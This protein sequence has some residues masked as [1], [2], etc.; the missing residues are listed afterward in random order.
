MLAKKERLTTAAFNRSFSVGRRYH[1]PTLTVV[2]D[3]T[4]T[5]HGAV[6]VGKKVF[7]KA[8]DRNRLRRQLYGAL[9]RWLKQTGTTGTYIII[10]KPAIKDLPSRAI[11]GTVTEA[12]NTLAKKTSRSQ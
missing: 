1:F 5:R 3:A 7:K 9:Y 10:A 12:L 4:T 11:A 6:V 8:V 2:Y